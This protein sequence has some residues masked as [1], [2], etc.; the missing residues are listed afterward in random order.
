MSKHNRI[1]SPFSARTIE[2]LNSPAYRA[3][4]LTGRRVLDRIEIAHA[5]HGGH[6]NGKLAVTFNQ[7]QEYGAR[8]HSIAPALRELAQLGFIEVTEQ[9]RAG[10]AD[11]RRPT[12]FRLTYRDTANAAATNEWRSITE[13]DAN[14]I[15]K[16]T[17]P[18]QNLSVPKRHHK[19]QNP[20]V[21]NGTIG[22]CRNGTESRCRNGTE[23][24]QFLGAETALLSRYSPSTGPKAPQA[25][26]HPQPTQ[27]PR[28]GP[29]PAQA[30]PKPSPDANL[31]L[32]IPPFLRRKP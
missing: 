15:A 24:P 8:R 11:W 21:R 4:S 26:H 29:K 18:P 23:P 2:M 17:R 27:F 28:P 5:R 10:N 25:S 6:D 7:F 12:L 20:S 31:D 9:G 19:K 30:A 14:T 22:R 16:G 32:D 3:L 1:G 13:D